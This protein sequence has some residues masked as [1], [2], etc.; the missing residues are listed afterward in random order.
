MFFNFLLL[1][2]IYLSGVVNSNG[3]SNYLEQL[4]VGYKK[5]SIHYMYI[6]VIFMYFQK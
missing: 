1:T 5:P 4:L 6:Y 3:I 2:S